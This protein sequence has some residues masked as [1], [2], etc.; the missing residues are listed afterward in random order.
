MALRHQAT[1]DSSPLE[2][3]LSHE[4]LEQVRQ[5]LQRLTPLD[6]D[7]LLAFYYHGQS[8]AA[9][10]QQ[11]AAPLGTIKRRLHMARKRLRHELECVT[12]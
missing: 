7:T 9:I 11:A 3:L 12:Q 10:S 6:R 2:Q 8:L 4:R 5:S 1:T